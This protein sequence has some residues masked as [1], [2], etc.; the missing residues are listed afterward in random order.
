MNP[1]LVLYL[2]LVLAAVIAVYYSAIA[3]GVV[4]LGLI[5]LKMVL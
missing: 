4:A 2:I 1:N 3:S 5:I